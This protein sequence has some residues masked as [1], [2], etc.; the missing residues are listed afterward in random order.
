LDSEAADYCNLINDY[1]RILDEARVW[2]SLI[3]RKSDD[4]D[5][6]FSKQDAVIVMLADG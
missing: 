4:N 6:E 1:C 5:T 2:V 3:S